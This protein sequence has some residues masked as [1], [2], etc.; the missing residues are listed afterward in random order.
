MRKLSLILRSSC[1]LLLVLS[2]VSGAVA[3]T[4]PAP[5]PSTGTGQ[6]QECNSAYDVL[7]DGHDS[8]PPVTVSAIAPETGVVRLDYSVPEAVNDFSVSLEDT[9]DLQSSKG[10]NETHG[11]YFEYNG[12]GEAQLTYTVN[13][14]NFTPNF[15]T[16]NQ[17]V[18]NFTDGES[19]VAT[20]I[21]PH[22]DNAQFRIRFPQGGYAGTTIMFVG[23]VDRVQ[24][25]KHGSHTLHIVVPTAANETAANRSIEGLKLG[26]QI[27]E[28][29][30]QYCNS[31][32][33]FHPEN[34][35]GYTNKADSVSG[36]EW[37]NR[38]PG[39][40]TPLHEYIHTQQR[41]DSASNMK[42]FTEASAE[43]LTARIL[44]DSGELSATE[45]D[46]LLTGFA[47]NGNWSNFSNP[48]TFSDTGDKSE[49][50]KGALILAQIDEDLRQNGNSTIFDLFAVVGETE[51]YSSYNISNFH[52]DYQRLGGNRSEKEFRSLISDPKTTVEPPY[53]T[54]PAHIL[55]NSIVRNAAYT[56]RTPKEV[57][58]DIIKR[59]AI[60]LGVVLLVIE[61][62][63]VWRNSQ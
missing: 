53:V 63:T 3:I 48:S 35:R 34:V 31:V 23:P 15:G 47:R 17:R 16:E 2:S 11:G 40:H 57:E 10:F 4:E 50:Y 28:P 24:T 32:L 60:L 20:T 13:R 46:A 42:W 41:Y 12:S 45:Y 39:T 36:D 25:I 6:L 30:H 21:I 8:G 62:A 7:D 1:C 59:L 26:M 54:E 22:H 9:H 14:S 37:V 51:D 58:I 18:S 43:Y 44:Y 61:L 55:P 5:I 38:Q 27:V 33:V 19:G 56:D 49:Y 29:I 52:A